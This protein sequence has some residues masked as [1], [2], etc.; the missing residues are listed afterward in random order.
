M[1]GKLSAK[2][3]AFER[4]PIEHI[5]YWISIWCICVIGLLCLL[6]WGFAYRTGHSEIFSCEIKRTLGIPCP[7]C[8]GTRAILS[9]LHGKMFRAIYY[10][11][12]VVYGAVWY[13]LFFFSQTLQRFSSGRVKGM[14]FHAAY[15]YVAVII[16]FVQYIL[17]LFME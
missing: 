15:L 14:R 1:P 17:K 16:L 7:G 5:L 11:A 8:G 2:L 4:N 9:L 12:F 13:L 6:A 3:K 10:N